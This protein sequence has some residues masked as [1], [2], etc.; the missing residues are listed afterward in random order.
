MGIRHGTDFDK[1]EF[2]A[3]GWKHG[4]FGTKRAGNLLSIAQV[5]SISMVYLPN[6]LIFMVNIGKYTIL[7][8][9]WGR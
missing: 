6:W 7:I 1:G 5:H 8:E 2:F 4:K 3:A 9:C